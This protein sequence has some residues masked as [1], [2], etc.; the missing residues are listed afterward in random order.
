M[1]L[2][3]RTFREN[4]YVPP[5]GRSLYGWRTHPI[6]G[7][8]QFHYG[9]DYQT[10]GNN[11]PLYALEGGFV[12]VSDYDDVNGNHI[13]INYP[14][15]DLKLFYGHLKVRYVALDDL[16]H[17]TSII[18]LAGTTG[19]STGVHLHLGAKRIS[20]NQYFNHHSY[21]WEMYSVN[22]RWD[23]QFTRD[24]QWFL[25]SIVDG[26]ISGQLLY[27]K[28]I[29]KTLL[30]VKGSKLVKSLQHSIGLKQTGQLD[31]STIKAL[32][33][34]FGTY[35]D[36]KISMPSDLVKVMQVR[37]NNGSLFGDNS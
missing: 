6:T 3:E 15:L 22:G 27:R 25:G 9:E 1:L 28:N 37:M 31:S 14:R 34:R 5:V 21:D 12:T 8:N 18:G 29:K 10:F 2:A 36:G 30:G 16:V 23:E 35:Q 19:R 7:L 17:A 11:Y 4:Q 32:Q 26:V 24:L 13:W 33:K 20:T